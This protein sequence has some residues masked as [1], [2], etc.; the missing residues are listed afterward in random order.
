MN[1]PIGTKIGPWIVTKIIHSEKLRC[2][3]V[4]R[5]EGDATEWVMKIMPADTEYKF[6]QRYDL[7]QVGIKLYPDV[8]IQVGTYMTHYT[9]FV[10][11]RY[12]TD[13]YRLG[14]HLFDVA[15]FVAA[16]MKF[17]KYLHQTHRMIHGDLKLGNI[18]YKM[19]SYCICDYELLK[20]PENSTICDE[21]DY[22][23]Y[24]Y[25]SFGAQYGKPIYSY[26][27][28]LEAVGHMLLVAANGH[29]TLPFQRRAH[30][31]YDMR[32]RSNHFPELKALKGQWEM[33]YRIEQYF[34]LIEEVEW[35]SLEPPAAAIYDRIVDL[36]C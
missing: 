6:I 32:S 23:N 20:E 8:A 3:A 7:Q 36:F 27:Y 33:P 5:L 26:R 17:L 14:P 25:W 2:L 11:E 28:D 30:Q 31:Y 19:G 16:V 35:T 13:S 9:W 34:K 10:M 22:D 18:L 24:Y 1:I 4:V 21:S 29:K 15:P 12:T